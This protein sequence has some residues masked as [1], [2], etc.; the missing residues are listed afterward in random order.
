M[1][2]SFGNSLFYL[3]VIFVEDVMKFNLELQ[4]NLGSTAVSKV[5]SP[6]VY[7]EAEH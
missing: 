6:I 1:T 4:I 3:S 2:W 5:K 7:A